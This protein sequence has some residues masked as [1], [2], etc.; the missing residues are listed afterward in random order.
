MTI[1]DPRPA[2]LVT[3]P[4]LHSLAEPDSPAAS[5]HATPNVVAPQGP[6]SRAAEE[7]SVPMVLA[8]REPNSHATIDHSLTRWA[9]LRGP[10]S[11]PARVRPTPDEQSPDGVQLTDRRKHRD[12]QSHSAVGVDGAQDR[13]AD[14]PPAPM[15]ETLLDPALALAA[16]FLDDVER[17]KLANENRLRALTRVGTD[18]DG[19]DRYIGLDV[20]HPVVAQLA[21]MVESLA[22]IEHA[23]TLNLQRMV[24]KH[25]L[26]PWIKATKGVGEKQGARLL[27]VIGDPYWRPEIT[28]ADGTVIP[29]GP[30]T[31]S[32]LWAYCGL[33]V[34]PSGQPE[35]DAHLGHAAGD[36]AGEGGDS[37]QHDSDD[38]LLPAGVA[39]RRRKGQQA[40]WSTKAKTRAYLI[41]ESSMKTIRQ[42][43]EPN[44]HAE[45]CACSPYRLVYDR[46][47]S[48]TS[49][50]RPDWTDGHRHADALRVASKEI[51]KDLWRAGRE[52]H[53][54]HGRE[55]TS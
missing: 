31:V 35:I 44:D 7:H 8:L 20:D 34:L 22:G 17:V 6:D 24:R 4:R 41:A 40:N 52:W 29:E 25:P 5:V 13:A 55:A 32:A 54:K 43:C 45:D 42:P 49:V 1:T 16:D 47:K 46:R 23:A 51:L 27:A 30:R 48:H 50:S 39:A 14:E 2:D 12:V 21:S 19:V 26:G 28:R 33:H 9:P 3:V 10:S 38:R 18:A 37:G 53:L 36:Q 11:R 15:A